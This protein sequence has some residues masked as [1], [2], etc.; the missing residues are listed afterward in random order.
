MEYTWN[1]TLKLGQPDIDAQH[2][3][4]FNLLME[5]SVEMKKRARGKNKVNKILDTLETYSRQHFELEEEHI[6]KNQQLRKSNRVGYAEFLRKASR[7]RDLFEQ[8]YYTQCRLINE[9]MFAWM[10]IHIRH[11]DQ[12]LMAN[13]LKV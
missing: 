4:M 13:V 5:L 7:I 1:D 12:Q 2:Q 6:V 3:E 8:G 9:E 11:V 10:Y